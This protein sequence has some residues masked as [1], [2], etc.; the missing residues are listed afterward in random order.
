MTIF[1][2]S[3]ARDIHLAL[4]PDCKPPKMGIRAAERLPRKGSGLEL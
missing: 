2:A 1:D 3:S 4:R